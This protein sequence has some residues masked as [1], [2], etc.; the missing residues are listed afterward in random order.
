MQYNSKTLIIPIIILFVFS[1][2]VSW[3]Q[4]PGMA[5]V[6]Q[7]WSNQFAQQQMQMQMNSM[8]LFN[9]ADIPNFKYDYEV[10]LK[11]ST[12]IM[13]K[14]KIYNDTSKHKTYLLLVDKSIPKSDMAHRERKIYPDQTLGISRQVEAE[15]AAN[16]PIPFKGMPTDSCWLFKT[17]TARISAYS[18]LGEQGDDFSYSTITGIQKGNGPI[19]HFSPDNLKQMIADDPDAMK[20]FDKKKYPKAIDRY[21]VDADKAVKK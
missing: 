10:I 17:I 9:N 21:N 2:K 14:S 16:R 8:M 3:G 18:F 20:F 1:A 12:K 6:R 15:D 13:V 7:Q 5:A 4:Y 19:I 11:D